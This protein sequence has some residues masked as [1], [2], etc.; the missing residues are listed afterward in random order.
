M[1]DIALESPCQQLFS[2]SLQRHLLV[3]AEML[4][5]AVDLLAVDLEELVLH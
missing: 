3:L 2:T 4:V 1:P 5:V